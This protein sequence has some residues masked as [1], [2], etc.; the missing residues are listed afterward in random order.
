MRLERF[1]SR[2]VPPP[3][4]KTYMQEV[5][6]GVAKIDILPLS[7]DTPLQGES[8]LLGLPGVT[9]ARTVVGPC[10]AG[11][12]KRQTTDGDDDIVLCVALEGELTWSWQ[13]ER[14]VGSGQAYLG[15][16][17]IPGFRI[18]QQSA[19][20]LDIVVPRKLLAASV[21]DAATPR[22]FHATPE[23]RLLAGYVQALIQ[24]ADELP[25]EAAPMA[26]SHIRDLAA[27]TL[28]ASRDAAEI[29]RGRGVRA[30]RLK[31]IK[32]DIEAN[33]LVPGLSPG[34]VMARHGISER[35]LRALFAD[36]ETSFTDF[37][38]EKRLAYVFRRLTGPHCADLLIAA[39]AYEA[40]F[41]DL[42]WFNRAF[43]RRFGMTPSEAREAALTRLFKNDR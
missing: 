25:D 27:L 29:A 28:G 18:F 3:L 22:P 21:M 12:T 17:D 32:A 15:S 36:E 43:R 14:Q 8:T 40:G 26:A 16:N 23:V 37:V 20:I 31:A 30:A 6:G 7:E 4:R 2:D 11:R 13:R 5:Y 33:L 35:Y 42:S 41:N 10:K 19:T 1:S 34:W 39:I 9:V 24:E 38:L